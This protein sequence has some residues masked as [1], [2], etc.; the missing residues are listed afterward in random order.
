MDKGRAR[1][2]AG[3]VRET[4][5]GHRDLNSSN[6]WPIDAHLDGLRNYET[7]W[8]NTNSCCQRFS[9]AVIE[10]EKVPGPCGEVEVR[11]IQRMGGARI[12]RLPGW[13]RTTRVSSDARCSIEGRLH[14]NDS[15]AFELPAPSKHRP[16]HGAAETNGHDD[17][18]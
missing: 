10:P 8:R 2:Q 3:G 11:A 16:G 12:E 13:G 7:P 15:S 5:S 14:W 4:Y 9:D 18:A 17:H 1:P 6:P